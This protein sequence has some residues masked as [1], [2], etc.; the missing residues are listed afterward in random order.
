[1]IYTNVFELKF[2]TV[3][4][5]QKAKI[6]LKRHFGIS[7]PEEEEP[8][9]I[10]ELFSKNVKITNYFASKILNTIILYVYTK[11]DDVYKEI[12]KEFSKINV[13]QVIN[14]TN[15]YSIKGVS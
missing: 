4:D 10:N 1:M 12:S 9:I 3:E 14:V 13:K 2:D 6:K 11:N 15:Q 8:R 7:I 5:L